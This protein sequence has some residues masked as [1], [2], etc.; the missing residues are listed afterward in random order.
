VRQNFTLG[1]HEKRSDRS[2]T[3]NSLPHVW[4]MVVMMMMIIIIIIV[5]IYS[6]SDILY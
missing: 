4:K 2:I 6:F 5:I 3:K 1:V